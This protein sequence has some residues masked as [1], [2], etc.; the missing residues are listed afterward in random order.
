MVHELKSY[1]TFTTQWNTGH[2]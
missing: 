2:I 1:S